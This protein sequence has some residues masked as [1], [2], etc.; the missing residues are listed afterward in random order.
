MDAALEGGRPRRAQDALPWQ[1]I[2]AIGP[3]GATDAHRVHAL[4]PHARP[5]RQ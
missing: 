4:L 3:E 1:Q 5:E 2:T